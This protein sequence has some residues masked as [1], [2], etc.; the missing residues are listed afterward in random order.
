MTRRAEAAVKSFADCSVICQL[1]AAKQIV[2]FK[3]MSGPHNNR[4]CTKYF[5]AIAFGVNIFLRCHTD[6]DFTVSVTQVFLKGCDQYLVVDRVVAF[7][8][9]RPLVLLFQ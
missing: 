6:E 2:P 8:V 5:G 4:H 9:S 7:F 1:L 3:T